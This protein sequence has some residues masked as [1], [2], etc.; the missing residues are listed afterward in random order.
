MVMAWE[1]QV[2]GDDPIISSENSKEDQT[3]LG[4]N[5]TT[6]NGSRALSNYGK[7]FCMR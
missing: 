2:L 6:A 5:G 7:H 4:A 3:A 1:G